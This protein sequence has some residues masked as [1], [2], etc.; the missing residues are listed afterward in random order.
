MIFTNIM[1]FFCHGIV[2]ALHNSCPEYEMGNRLDEIIRHKIGTQMSHK[3]GLLEI[4]SKAT[5]NEAAIQRCSAEI[6]EIKFLFH[7]YYSALN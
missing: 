4:N 3:M 2:F 7:F 6:L 5:N 1:A